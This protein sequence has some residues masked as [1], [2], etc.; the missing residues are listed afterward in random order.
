VTAERVAQKYA[1]SREEQD[2]FA[3]RSQTLAAAAIEAGHFDDQIVPVERPKADPFVR[4]E[5]PRPTTADQLAGLRPAFEADGTVTA[6]NSSGINDG[7]AAVILM[8]RSEAERRGLPARLVLC[9]WAVTGIEPELMGYAPAHSIP[10]AL[11]NAGIGIDDVD[12]VELNEAFAAQAVAV[13]RDAGLDLEKV[14]P[15]GGA[16]ALGHPVGATGA[17][18]TVKLMHAL[19]RTDGRYGVVSMCIGGGQGFAAVFERPNA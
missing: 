19:E 5:H 6:G 16:I 15:S 17:I 11:E 9:A 13:A 1:V 7:A 18:L 14:N 12:I 8:R 10:R 2:A 3:L 4:D